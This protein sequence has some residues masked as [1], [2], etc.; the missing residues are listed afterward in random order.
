[1][2][3][4]RRA[5]ALAL[6]GIARRAGAVVKGTD[7]TRRG[8]KAGEVGL[9]LVAHDASEAQLKKVLALAKADGVPVVRAGSRTELGGALG[10]G[11][12]SAVG[13]TGKSFVT[14]L[15]KVLERG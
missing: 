14:Q 5:E 4:S 1:M 15:Q 2:G 12:L 13:V 10:A 9:V 8:L 3:T 11:A 7:A 6:L